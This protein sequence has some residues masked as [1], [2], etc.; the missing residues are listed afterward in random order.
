MTV[1]G[2]HCSIIC[3]DD[4]VMSSFLCPIITFLNK[5][6]ITLDN[7]YKLLYTVNN[8]GGDAGDENHHKQFPDGAYL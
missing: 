2:G 8:K 7:S 3:M 4:K 5:H 1:D 6:R